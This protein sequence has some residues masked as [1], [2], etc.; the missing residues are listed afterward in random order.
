ML[1]GKP[2]GLGMIKRAWEAVEL[3]GIGTL[4]QTKLILDHFVKNPHSRMR[5]FLAVQVLS[6]SVYE[7]MKSYVEG[8]GTLTN[9]YS[10][11]MLLVSKLDKLIDMWNHPDK[12]GIFV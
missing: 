4:R 5:V 12:K 6:N 2:L 10:S 9:E 11:L 3:G 7:M 8:N 1:K